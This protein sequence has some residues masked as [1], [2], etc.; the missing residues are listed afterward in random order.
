MDGEAFD[1][2]DGSEYRKLQSV[3]RHSLPARL[4]SFPTPPSSKKPAP[5]STF[6]PSPST[7]NPA[8]MPTVK[9][10]P[11]TQKPATPSPVQPAPSRVKSSP[12]SIQKKR[13]MDDERYDDEGAVDY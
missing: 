4:P 11:L 12:A 6:G 13:A 7:Q 10:A 8:P 5:T 2:E 1:G 3:P 9:P